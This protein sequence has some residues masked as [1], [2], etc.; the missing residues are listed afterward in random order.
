MVVL[1]LRFNVANVFDTLG[2]RA[3]DLRGWLIYGKER[4]LFSRIRHGEQLPFYLSAKSSRIAESLTQLALFHS[5][6]T[7]QPIDSQASSTSALV[8]VSRE[9]Y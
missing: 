1:R 8:E 5:L 3:L 4:I 7:K 2:S 9:N 6:A